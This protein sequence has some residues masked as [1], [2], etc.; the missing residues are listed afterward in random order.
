MLLW[1]ADTREWSAPPQKGFPVSGRMGH[2]SAYSP[3]TG[4]I[5][6]EGGVVL[7]GD[8]EEITPQLLVYDP[9]LYVWNRLSAR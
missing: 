6:V 5:Y 3:N 7:N 4:L 8:N 2:A 1:I 9:V